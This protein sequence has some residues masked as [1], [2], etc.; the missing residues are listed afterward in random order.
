MRWY[1]P[2]LLQA[3]YKS[4]VA[5]LTDPERI[6]QMYWNLGKYLYSGDLSDQQ[7]SEVMYARRAIEERHPEVRLREFN[8]RRV[9]RQAKVKE[10]FVQQP[11]GMDHGVMLLLSF[12]SRT[13]RRIP[14]TSKE[15]F[16]DILARMIVEGQLDPT[17][18]TIN[19]GESAIP[20]IQF[21]AS[22]G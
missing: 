17:D 19:T 4:R 2:Q 11:A 10:I 18:L 3:V 12:D 7:R 5:K 21:A 6:Y 16:R 8:E 14:F 15:H 20:Y 9:G 1:D 13:P 22:S